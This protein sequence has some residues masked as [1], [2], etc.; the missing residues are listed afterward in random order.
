MSRSRNDILLEEKVAQ[1]DDINFDKIYDINEITKKEIDK[2]DNEI[3]SNNKDAVQTKNEDDVAFSLEVQTNEVFDNFVWKRD[4]NE[5][6]KR[7]KSKFSNKPLIFTFTSIMTLLCILFIYNMFV[8]NRLE[9]SAG[10]ARANMDN[11][12]SSVSVE[13]ENNYIAFENGNNLEI[14][15]YPPVENDDMPQTSNWFDNICNGVKQLFGGSS[16]N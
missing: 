10:Q 2:F 4:E 6:Q 1:I 16:L 3:L 7:E 15:N 8:I 14:K 12:S 5:K 9:F 11:V 13:Y